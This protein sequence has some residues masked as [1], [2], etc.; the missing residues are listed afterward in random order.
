MGN[1]KRVGS[2]NKGNKGKYIKISDDITLKKGQTLQL[3][4]PRES[5]HLT[6]EQIARIPEY[7]VADVMLPP[8]KDVKS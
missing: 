5:K 6:E 7:V 8:E 4:N 1:W 2:V 3:F